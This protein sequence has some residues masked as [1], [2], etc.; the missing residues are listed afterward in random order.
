MK[1]EQAVCERVKQAQEKMDYW[2]KTRKKWERMPEELWAEATSLAK[3]IGV[4]PVRSIFDLDYQA[5]KNRTA[6]NES[7]RSEISKSG[8]I[9]LKSQFHEP[10]I[11]GTRVGVEVE[12]SGPDGMRMNVR[13]LKGSEP[14][15]VQLIEAFRR[16][17]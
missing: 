1:Q 8:F 16:K 12:I 10:E 15:L 13:F 9:E 11:S 7:N 14:D 6:G 3:E 2:R 5:L 4:N 17:H